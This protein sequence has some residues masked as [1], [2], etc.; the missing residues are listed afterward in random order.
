[1]SSFFFNWD[2]LDEK[3]AQDMPGRPS[4]VGWYV[5]QIEDPSAGAAISEAIDA[6]FVNST[7]ETLTETEKAF[8]LGFVS[9]SAAIITGIR[10][11][12]LL[13]IGVVLLVL[14]NTIAPVDKKG[15]VGPEMVIKNARIKEGVSLFSPMVLY[16]SATSTIVNP[17][18]KTT[19]SLILMGPMERISASRFQNPLSLGQSIV[20]VYP[21]V[22]AL[23]AITLICF[24]I[25]YIIF[26]IQEIR[27]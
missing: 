17:M 14:A 1:V 25:S 11:V 22:V 20:V 26:M 13:I 16:S 12:S 8:A 15:E 4:H 21:H 24:A 23:V 19:S 3:M 5:V 9:M 2:Y 7:A 10:L 27:T 18:Q 6:L